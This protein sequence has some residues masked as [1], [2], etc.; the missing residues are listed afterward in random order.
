MT[1]RK[2]NRM[3]GCCLVWAWGLRLIPVQADYN[4]LGG[5]ND[6]S[7]S[8]TDPG[9]ERCHIGLYTRVEPGGG[10]H[11]SG[12]RA[13]TSANAGRWRDRGAILHVGFAE[14]QLGGDVLSEP[15]DLQVQQRQLGTASPGL[16]TS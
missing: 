10:E 14:L 11:A 9:G 16:L 13:D 15:L 1:G 2:R 6:E 8:C 7:I 5:P 12:H 4:P 3:Q